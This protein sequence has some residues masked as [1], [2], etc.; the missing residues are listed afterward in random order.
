MFH[1]SLIAPGVARFTFGRRTPPPFPAYARQPALGGPLPLGFPVRPR[2][3]RRG[4]KSLVSLSGL[5]FCDFYGTGEQAGRLRRNGTRKV[6]WNSDSYDYTDRTP[7][8]Y[9]SHPFVLALPRAGRGPGAIGIIVET[10][11]RCTIDLTRASRGPLFE[12]DGPPPAVVVIAKDTPRQVLESLASLTGTMPLPPRWTLGFHQCRFSYESAAQAMEVARGFRAR[13]I[14]CDAIWLDIDYMD[15]YRSFTFN[16]AAFPDPEGLVGALH[17][18]DFRVVCMLDPG[19]KVD[20]SYAPYVEGREQGHFITGAAG[21]ECH[22][23]VWP[24]LCAFPDFTRAGTRAWWAR[25]CEGLLAIGIDGLWNDMNEP[26]AF[27]VPSK[28]LPPDARHD[29]DA[30]LG[31]PGPH[32]RYHNLYGDQMARATRDAMASYLPHRRPFVLTRAGFLGTQRT[33]ATWTGD[34]R[35][36]ERHFRWSVP[37]ALNLGLSG[38]PFCGPDIGG[39]IGDTDPDLFARWMGVGAL[40]PFARA[41][42]NKGTRMHEPWELGEECERT[43]RLALERRYRLL[44]YLYTLFHEASITGVPI[45]RPLFFADPGNRR[46]RTIDDAFLLGENVLLAPPGV[47]AGEVDARFQGW[48]AFELTDPDPRLASLHLRPGAILPVG[49]VMQHTAESPLDPLTLLIH[50]HDGCARGTLYEDDG[51]SLA[52][53][54][55]EFLLTDFEVERGGEVRARSTGSFKVPPR[56]VIQAVVT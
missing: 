13:S 48:A 17:A 44:P 12:V 21:G 52:Y 39:F 40:L 9:Q 2:L 35:A 22:A 50:F 41:H 11:R 54:Q 42:K 34:N 43:C 15:G 24:G 33:A 37:M 29:A 7:S 27:G 16:P 25:L 30:D 3:A 8:L 19:L 47:N 1:G 51:E 10:T 4:R 18:L 5:R 26:A 36:D 20:D 56:R 14:P 28:T 45:A 32:A 38:Q 55:G 31:G 49:P 23:H 46:V 53:A 6:L